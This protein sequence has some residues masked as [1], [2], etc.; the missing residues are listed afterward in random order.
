MRVFEQVSGFC[1]NRAKYGL[2]G[3]NADNSKVR[4][5]TETIG[6]ET[7][8]WPF[9]VATL[10]V[11]L[12]GTAQFKVSRRLGCWKMSLFSMGGRVF[13]LV[14]LA[15][16]FFKCPLFKVPPDIIKQVKGMIRNF[17]CARYGK[18]GGIT[19]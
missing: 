12:F 8:S 17:L 2:V 1:I 7:L 15:S 5:L 19:L 6:R 3:I 13:R 9:M 14:C 11:N 18:K 16:L 4:N 10:G